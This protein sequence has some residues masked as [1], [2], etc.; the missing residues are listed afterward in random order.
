MAMT[1]ELATALARV[2]VLRR[3]TREEIE[4]IAGATYLRPVVE[5]EILADVDE[6]GSDAFIIRDGELVLDLPLDDDRI[7]ARLGPG[8]LVGEV[9]LIEPGPRTLRIRAGTAG[10]VHV[11]DGARFRALCDAGDPGAHKVVQAI[12]HTLATRLREATVRLQSHLSVTDG[13]PV[14]APGPWTRLKLLFAEWL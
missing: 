14:E 7:V 6:I 12:A 3:L 13:E 2:P 4:R 8:A 9:C 1:T 5:G 11:L 10:S